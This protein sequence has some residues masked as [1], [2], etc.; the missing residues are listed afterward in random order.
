MTSPI[1]STAISPRLL[2]SLSEKVRSHPAVAAVPPKR[3]LET[4]LSEVIST[5]VEPISSA[6]TENIFESEEEEEEKESTPHGV[7][8]TLFKQ[9]GGDV[10]GRTFLE[11]GQFKHLSQ[12]LEDQVKRLEEAQYRS[13]YQNPI[14]HGA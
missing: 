8:N 1:S 3:A 5:L 6:F 14:K 11:S 12:I 2:P 10:W 7:N 4:F 13:V 9:L